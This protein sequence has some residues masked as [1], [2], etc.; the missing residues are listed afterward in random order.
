[1]G[2]YRNEVFACPY[3]LWES[4]SAVKC[5]GGTIRMPDGAA[6]LDYFWTYCCDVSGWRRCTVARAISRHYE[7]SAED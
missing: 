7:T 4:K 5:E 1:M 3:Y 2:Y 6:A